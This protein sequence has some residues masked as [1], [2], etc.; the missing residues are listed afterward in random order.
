MM[1]QKQAWRRLGWAL[2]LWTCLGLDIAQAASPE[3]APPE[4]EGYRQEAYRAPTPT[5]LRGAGVIDTQAA[6]ALWRE[7]NAIFIDVLPA[8]LGE[9]LH[10]GHWLPAKPRQDIPGSHWLPNVGYGS[11]S[12]EM[13]R[14]FRTTLGTLRQ[15]DNRPLVFYCLTD[16]WMSW[17]AAKRA[18]AW[19][20]GPILW[21]PAGSDGW[22]SE[23]LPLEETQPLPLTP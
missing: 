3:P 5:S 9:G 14:Y 1:N 13:E 21:Y 4:P 15:E 12:P 11:L 17:N 8:T 19:G 6:E 16:C 23:G 7:D 20:Y 22:S 18:L 10:R 2:C